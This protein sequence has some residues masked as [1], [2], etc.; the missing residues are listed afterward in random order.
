MR[1]T[2][3]LMRSIFLQRLYQPLIYTAG[4]FRGKSPI[5]TKWTPIGPKWWPII[6]K[7]T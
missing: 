4:N 7:G 6:H 5:E 2:F 3:Y 1:T